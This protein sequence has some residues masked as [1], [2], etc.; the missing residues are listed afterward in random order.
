MNYVIVGPYVTRRDIFL[1]A[2]LRFFDYS[3][4]LSLLS[5]SLS[6]SVSLCLSISLSFLCM[7]ELARS[8]VK[9]PRF[10]FP[11]Q[12]SFFRDR[13]FS[14]RCRE[15]TFSKLFS[16]KS[17]APKW[18]LGPFYSITRHSQYLTSADISGELL[19]FRAADFS[20]NE[21]SGRERVIKM[22]K[23]TRSPGIPFIEIFREDDA[24]CQA[25]FAR[26][27]KSIPEVSLVDWPEI[28]VN[29]ISRERIGKDG[30]IYEIA[31]ASHLRDAEFHRIRWNSFHETFS[32]SSP[33]LSCFLF[34]CLVVIF[35][36]NNHDCRDLC[37]INGVWI[38]KESRAR[39]R[40][41]ECPLK[42]NI[43]ARIMNQ[44]N[45]TSH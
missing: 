19:R 42:R 16:N 31:P 43:Q 30:K 20:V 37:A 14:A 40:L 6:L 24:P 1:D 17:T 32:S 22:H 33:F 4:S 26:A 18:D 13:R 36:R 34:L 44:P 35:A 45:Y 39:V 25:S 8:D 38:L 9:L 2:L 29:S 11:P 5:L 10:S 27:A 3:L 15:E 7:R 23:R 28:V 41:T 12:S 21:T